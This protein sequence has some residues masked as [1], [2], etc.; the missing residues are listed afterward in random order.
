MSNLGKIR[1]VSKTFRG[2]CTLGLVALPLGTVLFWA[3]FNAL[4]QTMSAPFLINVAT[5]TLGWE[6]R[7]MACAASMLPVGALCYGFV[8][9]RRLFGLYMEGRIFS[10]ANVACYRRLGR[11]LLFWAAAQFLD[12]PLLTL[13][14]TSANPPGQHMITIGVGSGELTALFLGGVVLLVSWVMDEGRRL[15]E[16]QLLTI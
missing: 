2:L 10:P 4:P 11:S 5:P 1:T 9:L 6:A 14:L 7:A 3:G 12:G 16:D 8:C 13:A 15:E